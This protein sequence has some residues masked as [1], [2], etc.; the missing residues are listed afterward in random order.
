MTQSAREFRMGELRDL[1][2]TVG[3]TPWKIFRVGAIYF[4][5]FGREGEPLPLPKLTELAAE[6]DRK[7]RN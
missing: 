2:F 6:L 7:P 4:G 3:V 5:V 1:Q